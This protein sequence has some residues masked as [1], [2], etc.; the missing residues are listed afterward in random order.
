MLLEIKIPDK[1]KLSLDKPIKIEGPDGPDVPEDLL[2]TKEGFPFL[3]IN[4]IASNNS[5][6]E[7]DQTLFEIWAH[8]SGNNIALVGITK[9]HNTV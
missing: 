4:P 3:W 5:L 8:N 9:A 6:V 1:S 2:L 7:K